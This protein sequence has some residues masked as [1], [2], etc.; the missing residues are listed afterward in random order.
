[1][2]VKGVDLQPDDSFIDFLQRAF[3]Y[4][5]FISLD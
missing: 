3:F 1:V 4:K 2:P 5:L